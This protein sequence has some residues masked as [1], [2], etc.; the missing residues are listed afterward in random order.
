MCKSKMAIP[1]YTECQCEA[2]GSNLTIQKICCPLCLVEKAISLAVPEG[3]YAYAG[4]PF[5][6]AIRAMADSIRDNFAALI[7]APYAATDG[8]NAYSISLQGLC[9][10]W[11]GPVGRA[12]H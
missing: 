10:D 4:Q 5:V 9:G 7:T 3:G 12:D 8:E 6:V 2:R 1:N 11:N